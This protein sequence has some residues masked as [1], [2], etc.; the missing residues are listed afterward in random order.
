MQRWIATVL[1]VL[2]CACSG[3]SPASETTESFIHVKDGRIYV[4][5]RKD[6]AEQ[7][8]KSPHL[9]YTRTRIGEGP[10]GA[11]LIFEVDKKD[12]TLVEGLERAWDASA[13]QDVPFW[14]HHKDGRL[15]V[16][17]QAKTNE[18]FIAQGHM[19][20]AKT[21]IGEGPHGV[22]LIFEIDKK[23]PELAQKLIRAFRQTY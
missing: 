9:P 21:L 14:V 22:T 23:N 16:I 2:T 19:P 7:F 18:T 4:I 5:G 8:I 3:G 20:Y 10:A 12:P 15:Y 1:A 13:G 6:T 11:T 17:G